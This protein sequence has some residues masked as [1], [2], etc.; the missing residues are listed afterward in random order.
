MRD[1][2]SKNKLE[3]KELEGLVSRARRSLK[4]L[5]PEE[6]D[7]LDRLY[8]RTAVQLAQVAARTRD[9]SLVSYL[10]H[11]TAAAHTVIYLSPKS[12]PVK[13]TWRFIHEGFARAV[14]RTW[15]YHLTAAL[16]M[17][18][19]G[20]LAYFAVTHDPTAAYALLPSGESRLP[21]ST[22]TQLLEA[23]TQGQ[24]LGGGAKF[25]FAS[26]LF[27]HNLKVGLLAMATGI[28]AALPTILL[29]VYNGMVL[30]AFTAVHHSHN[31][32]T[33]YWAWILPHG[34]TEILATVLCGGLGLRLGQAVISP[35]L[36]TRM[37][38][39]RRV[40]MEAG[41]ISLG[42][43]GMF[44]LAAV[45]ESYLRQSHLS[46]RLRFIFAGGTLLFWTLYFTRGIM[47]QHL[48]GRPKSTGSLNF[49]ISPAVRKK[50]NLGAP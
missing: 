8:R 50:P 27:S 33:E 43:A 18:L 31:I 47:R 34:V 38:S 16:L 29:T 14:A 48:A 42:V 37:H 10:N 7:R 30:G 13:S 15:R 32:Y 6:I 35:G 20:F 11:L 39:L 24:N 23:L 5:R 19:G 46:T 3:W 9:T 28:L 49:V 17:G 36:M 44:V 4:R 12:S 26:V 2:I 1:S 45:I 22:R 25:I 41:R 40:G 21:G